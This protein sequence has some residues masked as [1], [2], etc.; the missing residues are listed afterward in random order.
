MPWFSILDKTRAMIDQE[1]I[2]D[3]NIYYPMT[4]DSVPRIFVNP[5]QEEFE[6]FIKKGEIATYPKIAFIRDQMK[7]NQI[8]ESCI[9]KLKHK[10]GLPRGTK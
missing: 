7:V 2:G 10:M 1:Y 3:I 4:F 9:S 5:T 8:L 6:D